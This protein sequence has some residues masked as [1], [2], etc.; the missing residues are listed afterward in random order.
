MMV[1]ACGLILGFTGISMRLWWLQVRQHDKLAAE[2]A[3]LRKTRITLTSLR[4]SI[5]DRNGELLAQDRELHEFYIDK[6]HL[7]DP[8]FVRQNYLKVLKDRGQKIEPGLDPAKLVERYSDHLIAKLAPQVG[9]AEQDLRQ[10]LQ[11]GG[12]A[13]PVLL[14]DLHNQEARNM[15]KFLADNHLC[16]V[17]KRSKAERFRPA[18]K[19]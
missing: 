11:P 3:D 15:E 7:G 12:V 13:S 18:H 2:A 6:N 9:M 4:G 14:K 5:M 17:Y 10:V 1:V 16:A 19:G 8:N